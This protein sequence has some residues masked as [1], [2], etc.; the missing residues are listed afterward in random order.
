LKFLE[1][2]KNHLGQLVKPLYPID[3]AVDNLSSCTEVGRI[4]T[5]A[6]GSRVPLSS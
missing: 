3:G 2:K 6:T 1:E 4:A 5:V